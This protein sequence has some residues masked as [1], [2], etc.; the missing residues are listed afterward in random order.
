MTEKEVDIEKLRAVLEDPATTSN[1]FDEALRR[2]KHI[3][4][5][6]K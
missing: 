3:L 6:S 5:M 1:G 2:I 4:S